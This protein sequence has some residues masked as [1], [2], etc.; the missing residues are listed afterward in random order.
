MTAMHDGCCF[1]MY[2]CRVVSETHSFVV[3]RL[4]G[5]HSFASEAVCVHA[6]SADVTCFL[7]CI[8]EHTKTSSP[9]LYHHPNLFF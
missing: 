6:V 7:F 9:M 1:V 5:E 3:R 8:T 2:T 4:S